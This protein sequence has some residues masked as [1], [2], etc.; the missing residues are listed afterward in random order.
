M[1]ICAGG[2]HP[3]AVEERHRRAPRRAAAAAQGDHRDPVRGA[4][5]QGS[6]VIIVPR[7]TE[8]ARREHQFHRILL[9]VGI[10]LKF[11]GQKVVATRP[12]HTDFNPFERMRLFLIFAVYCSTGAVCYGDVC[13]GAEHAGEDR[14]LYRRQEIRRQGH[15]MGAYQLGFI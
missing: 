11:F 15:E 6:L 10:H 5:H 1:V 8:L 2:A 9:E 14:T 13:N 12:A 3:P 4:A 7:F